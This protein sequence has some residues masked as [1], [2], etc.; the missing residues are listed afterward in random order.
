[1]SLADWCAEMLVR[2]SPNRNLPAIRY[3]DHLRIENKRVDFAD[4][5]RDNFKLQKQSLICDVFWTVS[6]VRVPL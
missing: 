4:T 3:I 2:L 6:P 5:T 1:M